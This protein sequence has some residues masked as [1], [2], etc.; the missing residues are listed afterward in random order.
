VGSDYLPVELKINEWTV[1]VTDPGKTEIKRYRR[2][3]NERRL[4]SSETK[5]PS[6][7]RHPGRKDLETR[8]E[9]LERELYLRYST[10]ALASV[11]GLDK[12]KD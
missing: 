2:C 9:R 8:G 6:Q 11:M 1:N 5:Q 12:G 3:R 7:P 10:P 4:K